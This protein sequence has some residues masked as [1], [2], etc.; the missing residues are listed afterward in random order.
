V[1]QKFHWYPNRQGNRRKPLSLLRRIAVKIALISRVGASP[2]DLEMRS[3]LGEHGSYI[4]SVM[5]HWLT[6]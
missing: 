1:L 4:G 2:V 3:F 5:P 6:K